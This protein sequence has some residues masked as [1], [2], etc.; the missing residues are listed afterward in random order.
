MAAFVDGLADLVAEGGTV[1]AGPRVAGAVAEGVVGIRDVPAEPVM[2]DVGGGVL[3]PFAGP[4]VAWR[5]PEHHGEVV[6]RVAAVAADPGCSST[7]KLVVELFATLVELAELAPVRQTLVCH[8]CS[9]RL[10][11]SRLVRSG[12]WS[13]RWTRWCSPSSWPLRPW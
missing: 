10:R 4:A 5:L 1:Q 6:G 9:A 2:F 11:R 13:S 3:P 8:H 12:V 7:P